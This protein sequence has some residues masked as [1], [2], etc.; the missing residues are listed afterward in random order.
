MNGGRSS[1]A[2]ARPWTSPW[3]FLALAAVAAGLHMLFRT[4]PRGVAVTPDGI[5][6][7]SS[8][9]NLL[10]GHGLVD[11]SGKPLTTWPPLMALLAAAAGRVGVDPPE[12][13]R[14][15]NAAALTATLWVFGRWLATRV[16]R[17]A[18]VRVAVAIAAV[19][20]PLG[21]WAAHMLSEMLMCL[22]VFAV[23]AQLD[24][25]L[26][27]A[28]GWRAPAL[29]GAFAGLAVATRYPAAIL[30]P[31]G[32]V[33]LLLDRRDGSAA[34]LRRAA[35]FGGIA[36]APLA[37]IVGRNW[38]LS[39]T[40]TGDRT[41]YIASGVLDSLVLAGKALATW[42][43]PGAGPEWL[44]H[45]PWLAASATGVLA[46]CFM[47]ACPRAS[48][49]RR[50]PAPLV[51]PSIRLF[52]AFAGVY[53]AFLFAVVPVV[54]ADPI[55]SRFLVPAFLPALAV[56]ALLADR[57]LRIEVQ[58]REAL[59]KRAL[60]AA[61]VVACAVHAAF[62]IRQ[63]AIVTAEWRERG[64]AKWGAYNSAYWDGSA[65]LR[66]MD[67]ARTGAV[68]YSNE[69]PL[70][71]YHDPTAPLGKYRAL[72]NAAAAAGVAGLSIGQE[73]RARPLWAEELGAQLAPG[74]SIVWFE[75]RLFELMRY[76]V[77]DIL[78]VPGVRLVAEWE[79]GKL[80][81]VEEPSAVPQ[82]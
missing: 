69:A 72:P 20:Y 68:V 55:G 14:W 7:W 62:A 41:I 28:R 74:N 46:V 16:R 81:R 56:A 61:L 32:S 36:T 5:A 37:V 49:L 15:I 22:F 27:G 57:F 40:P 10:A 35:I 3:V 29:A 4:A 17:R 34:R 48:P 54:S 38:M 44:G 31:F 60:A 79:D 39:G 25:C 73:E 12:A 82:P 51:N 50:A 52:S 6:T 65:T 75:P 26:R 18:V 78:A 23:L 64:N 19:S 63:N 33:A 1:E 9:L 8:A 13:V 43:L 47:V 67:R 45:L 59:A 42:A 24:E 53:V 58:G 66:N 70:L 71:W 80:L 2:A 76:G 77:S 30:I 21:Y 11:F